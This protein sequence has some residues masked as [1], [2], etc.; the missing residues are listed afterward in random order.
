MYCIVIGVLT[1]PWAYQ[2]SA[3]PVLIIIIIIAELNTIERVA[4]T[5]SGK[6]YLVVGNKVKEKC[7]RCYAQ[8]P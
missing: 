6:G 8:L 1:T 3:C 2:F 5:M 4:E 7:N